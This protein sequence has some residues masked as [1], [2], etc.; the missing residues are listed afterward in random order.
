VLIKMPLNH[1]RMQAERGIE[2]NAAGK[3][4]HAGKVSRFTAGTIIA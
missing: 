2:R 4:Q 1:D 3:I